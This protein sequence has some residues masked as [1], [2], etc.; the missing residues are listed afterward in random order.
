[1]LDLSEAELAEYLRAQRELAKLGVTWNSHVDLD[2]AV[3]QLLVALPPQL[4]R[5]CANDDLLA[6]LLIARPTLRNHNVKDSLARLRGAGRA[7]NPMR[8]VWVAVTE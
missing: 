5:P 3:Y 4:G 6:P 8:G 7:L 2:N 1:M